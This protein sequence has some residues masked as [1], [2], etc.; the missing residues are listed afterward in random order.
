MT[1]KNAAEHA[2]DGIAESLFAYIA[3]SDVAL[4]IAAEQ[5]ADLAARG[6]PIEK[7]SALGLLVERGVIE[8]E[9]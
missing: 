7:E 5:I 4:S 1:S 3:S 6:E 8:I 2:S 9:N